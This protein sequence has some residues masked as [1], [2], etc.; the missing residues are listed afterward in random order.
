MSHR[1]KTIT[2]YRIVMKSIKTGEE[3]DSMETRDTRRE[4]EHAAM[5]QN[6]KFPQNAHWVKEEEVCSECKTLV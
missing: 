1:Y 5:S 3:W 4:A 2:R 6:I